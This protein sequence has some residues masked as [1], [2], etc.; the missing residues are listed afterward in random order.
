[1]NTPNPNN[2]VIKEILALK[3]ELKSLR[4][5]QTRRGRLLFWEKIIILLMT[6]IVANSEMSGMKSVAPEMLKTFL[7]ST[8]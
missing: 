4:D 1:M 8:E 7:E 6:M 2:D 5:N 3:E